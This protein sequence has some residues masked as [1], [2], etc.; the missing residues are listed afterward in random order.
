MALHPDCF[1]PFEPLPDRGTVIRCT[2]RGGPQFE[3]MVQRV[4]LAMDTPVIDVLPMAEHVPF[5]EIGI[6]PEL[7]DTWEPV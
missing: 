4:W 5:A 6:M 3:A 2:K 1:V 7:G